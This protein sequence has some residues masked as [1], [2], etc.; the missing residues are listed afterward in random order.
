ML[1]HARF[2]KID[3]IWMVM[4]SLRLENLSNLLG[5]GTPSA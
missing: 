4:A 1:L 3:R 5:D 2:Q